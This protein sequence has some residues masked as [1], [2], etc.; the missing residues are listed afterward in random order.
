MVK[1]KTVIE[2]RLKT[3]KKAGGKESIMVVV[4]TILN[5]IFGT[6]LPFLVGFY[7]G[8]TSNFYLLAVFIVMLLFDVR[9]EATHNGTI[10]IMII[11]G[12]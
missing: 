1:F 10:K 5:L 11:R 6:M 3:T 2:P 4:A 8:V 7:F 9:F 12:I